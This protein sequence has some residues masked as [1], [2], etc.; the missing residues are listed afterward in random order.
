M[1]TPW[2]GAVG[3]AVIVT[4]ASWLVGAVVALPVLYG[5][6]V[7]DWGADTFLNVWRPV[8]LAG[9]V[10]VLAVARRVSAPLPWW[11]ATL[12]DGGLYAA[13]LVAVDIASAAAGGDGDPVSGGFAQLLFACFTLQ[14]PAALGL[15][16]WRAQRLMVVVGGR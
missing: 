12:V 3:Y 15:V 7:G 14:L 8:F 6:D 13:V 10:V 4:L 16:A 9:A 11:R 5:G 1:I 2:R